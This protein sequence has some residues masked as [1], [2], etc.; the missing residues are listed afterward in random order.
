[1][2]ELGDDFQG[3]VA[4]AVDDVLARGRIDQGIF[5]TVNGKYGH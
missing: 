5:F 4:D 1:M 3:A 2:T